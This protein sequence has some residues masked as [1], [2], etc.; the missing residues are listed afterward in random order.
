[1]KSYKPETWMISIS[2]NKRSYLARE[3]VISSWT[4]RGIEVHH[5]EAT[6]PDDLYSDEYSDLLDRLLIKQ[7]TSNKVKWRSFSE[8]E[9]C[10]WISHWLL[11]KYVK[12]TNSPILI[13]EQDVELLKNLEEHL[14]TKQK[15]LCMS[16]K[17][18]QR[19]DKKLVK[20]L[21]IQA[22]GAYHITPFAANVLL[23]RLP[24]AIDLNV[25]NH[26]YRVCQNIGWFKPD[27]CRSI[28]I[29]DESGNT[30]TTIS[31][32]KIKKDF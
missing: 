11:W 27:L 26:I 2:G 10:V 20:V 14:F 3:K 21:K 22:A 16:S 9:K 13:I 4:S 6:T 29:I 8:T 25:D 7:P 15:M 32:P 12:E 28:D 5:W 23:D 19:K 1:M 24:D 31:H 18:E 17:Y 30:S